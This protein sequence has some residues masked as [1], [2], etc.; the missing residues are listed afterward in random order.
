MVN[1][2]R[3]PPPDSCLRL[4]N[5][6]RVGATLY[7]HIPGSARRAKKW[8]QGSVR[9]PEIARRSDQAAGQESMH[10]GKAAAI[11]VASR[12]DKDRDDLLL[13]A[14]WLD[15]NA[16]DPRQKE[17]VRGRGW[18]SGDAGGAVGL[19]HVHQD[20]PEF[21]ELIASRY[22]REPIALFTAHGK[23][24]DFPVV[25]NESVGATVR[26]YFT[27]TVAQDGHVRPSFF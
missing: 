1:L 24:S 9:V 21:P 8:A 12:W 5:G 20:E 4:Q 2:C 14:E 22:Q 6:V 11:P 19:S 18:N 17:K 27:G 13:Q 26:C 16:R 25:P 7:V 10:K 23:A 3:N 15:K